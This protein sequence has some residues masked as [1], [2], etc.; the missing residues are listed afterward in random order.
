MTTRGAIAALVALSSLLAAAAAPDFCRGYPCPPF[1]EI[2]GDSG[3]G[4][5]LRKY[6]KGAMAM[7]RGTAS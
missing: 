4:F 2:E 7:R 3:A 1:D 6:A 5:T